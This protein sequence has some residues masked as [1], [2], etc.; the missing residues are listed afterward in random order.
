MKRAYRVADVRAAEEPLLAA[1][2]PLMAEAAFALASAVTQHLRRGGKRIP[3]AKVLA[4]VGAGNNGGDALFAAAHLARRGL[5]VNAACHGQVHSAGLAAARAAGVTILNDPCWEELKT[6][7]EAAEIWLD[8]LLGI[9]ARGALRAPL[10]DWVTR[11]AQLRIRSAVEPYVIAVDVPSGVGVDDGTL[12]GAVL[13][14]D[15]TVTMGVAKRALYLPPACWYAGEIIPVPLGFEPYLPAQPALACLTAADVRD[16]WPL[17][18]HQDH[19]YTRG[20]LGVLAGS[21]TYP[22]A[23]MLVTGGAR[24]I[25]VGMIRY[26]GGNERVLE[27]YPDVVHAEGQ[28]QA[29][30]IGSGLADLGAASKVLQDALTNSLPVVLDA[31]AIELTYRDDVPSTVVVTP[32][33]GELA[34]L[35]QARGERLSREEVQQAPARAARLAATLTGATVVLKGAVNVIAAP[36][37]PLYA[38]GGAPAWLATAGAGDVL[39]GVLGALLAG[40]GDELAAWGSGRG[41]PGQLA[42]AACYVHARAAQ[43]AARALPPAAET[44]QVAAAERNRA[45]AAASRM[46]AAAE[47]IGI[48]ITASDVVAALPQAIF[49]ILNPAGNAPVFSGRAHISRM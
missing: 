34:A 2:E 16:V 39:A 22:G 6:A 8:G 40:Y 21:A 45:G 18:G 24:A 19:K 41:L 14:A 31:K 30:T 38:Q 26:L 20:V 11:L 46:S 48:P 5:A 9:G 25:G 23:G 4:L 33:A 36:H 32:H 44:G 49:E 1:G 47:N 17:P 29:W 13:P 43:I 10:A 7:A 15:A 37:G 27:R 35:L 42:A 28:V 3:G 12:P